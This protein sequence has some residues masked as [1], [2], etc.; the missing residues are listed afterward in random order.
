MIQAGPKLSASPRICR[1]K[2]PVPTLPRPHSGLFGRSSGPYQHFSM[3]ILRAV[4]RGLPVVRVANTGISGVIDPFGR[5]IIKSKL[6]TEYY[7]KTILPQKTDIT[8][9]TKY[10]YIPLFSILLLCFLLIYYSNK[11]LI[12]KNKER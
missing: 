1:F 9:Y 11:K 10:G 8:F 2:A 6:N 3:S 5:V 7:N 4:E 12:S